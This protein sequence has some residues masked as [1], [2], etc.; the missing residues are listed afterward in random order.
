MRNNERHRIKF[1]LQVAGS[2]QGALAQS[3]ATGAHQRQFL[4]LRRAGRGAKPLPAQ[5]SVPD[6]PE[7]LPLLLG[8]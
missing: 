7:A 8:T 4:H 6:E 5:L 2:S 1:T 3:R